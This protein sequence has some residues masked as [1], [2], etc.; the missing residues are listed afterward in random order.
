M[1]SLYCEKGTNAMTEAENHA[2]HRDIHRLVDTLPILC[3][4]AEK[5]IGG[6]EDEAALYDYRCRWRWRT[7]R[8]V[9]EQIRCGY[10]TYC[11]R[12]A[13]CG[14]AGARL[15]ACIRRKGAREHS[16]QG[17]RHGRL[18]CREGAGRSRAGCDFRVCQGILSRGYRA[19]HPQGSRQGHGSYS[20][21]QHLRHG[22]CP[23]GG[24]A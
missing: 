12:K 15:D 8:R 4:N 6:T 20:G 3:Y 19:V 14:P 21:A 22:P 17:D 23:A 24:A 7:G 2:L 13:S 11:T 9:F 5:A 1:K 18:S 16:G 10:H